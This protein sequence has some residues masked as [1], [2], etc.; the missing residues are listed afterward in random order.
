M[1]EVARAE[2]PTFDGRAGSFA[3]YVEKVILRK[4]ISTMG[5]E[6]E[7]AH[8]LLHMSDVARKVC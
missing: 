7:A 6:K 8:L 5:P 1:T 4:R 2:V 3:N